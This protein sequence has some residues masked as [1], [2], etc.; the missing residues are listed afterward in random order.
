[1]PYRPIWSVLQWSRW[2]EEDPEC[3]GLP[4]RG[5]PPPRAPDFGRETSVPSRAIRSEHSLM[6]PAQGEPFIRRFA[7]VHQV[8]KKGWLHHI[9]ELLLADQGVHQQAFGARHVAMLA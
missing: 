2:P 1:M 8:P 4:K 7:Q 5:N 3:I 9:F 6:F